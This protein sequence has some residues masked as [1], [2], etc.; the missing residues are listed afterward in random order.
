[1]LSLSYYLIIIF[2]LAGNATGDDVMPTSDFIGMDVVPEIEVLA[3][4]YLNGET[5]S[6]DMVQGV[7][8]FGEKDESA[9]QGYRNYRRSFATV[10][11]WMGEYAVY[12]IAGIITVTFGV[13]ALAKVVKGHHIHLAHQPKPNKLH[14]YYLWRKA[15]LEKIEQDRLT[16]RI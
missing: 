15:Y 10:S 13:V 6:H 14:T 2:S 12:L 8:V 3:P 9:E 4:K 11:T 7:T 16:R 5:D 1:M